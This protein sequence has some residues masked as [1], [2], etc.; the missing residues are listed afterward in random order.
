MQGGGDAQPG[1]VRLATEEIFREAL[2]L[3]VRG[4]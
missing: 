2:L 1:V 3:Q 4:R